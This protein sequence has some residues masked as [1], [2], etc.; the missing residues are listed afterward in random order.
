MSAK[1]T[2]KKRASPGADEEKNPLQNVELSDEDANRLQGVQKSIARVELQLE[3]KAQVALVPAYEERRAVTKTIS[4]FWP[5]ALMNHQLFGFLAQ[6]KTDQLALSY[7]ED[8][9]VARDSQEPRCYTIEFHFKENP[10]FT[11]SVL[12]KT[13][14]YV[15]HPENNEKPGEDGI[16]DAMLEFAWERDAKNEPTTINWK[17]DAHNLVKLY[18][19]EK[20]D[21]GDDDDMPAEP[22]SFFNFFTT[23]T[24]P[25][26]V[27]TTIAN[28]IFPEAIDYFLGNAGNEEA[29]SD[30]EEEESDDDDAEEIDLEKPRP[31]KARRA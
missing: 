22:G 6:H 7:L 17:D 10:F 12:K 21:D 30:D 29:G 28:E 31:K 25:Y 19:R 3:R 13:F 26:D 9:W 23:S 24:D 8:L 4:K 1:P 16:T 18:P 2:A 11:D 20:Q 27:G 14:S 5:I 15:A